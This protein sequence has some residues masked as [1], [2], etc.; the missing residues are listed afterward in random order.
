M[1]INTQDCPFPS[2]R[3][4]VSGEP[5]EDFGGRKAVLA[6]GMVGAGLTALCFC[7]PWSIALVG[8]V[9]V[10]LLS[11]VESEPFLLFIIFL[12]PFGLM[13]E[14][15][16][17]LR[18]VPSAVRSLV[19]V[20]FFLGRLW[21]GRVGVRRLLSSSPARASLFFLGAITVPII[22]GW[23]N[24]S[25]HSLW[26]ASYIGFFFLVSAWADSPERVRKILRVLLYSTIITAV[27]AI[28]QE[29]VVWYTSFWLFLYPP[30]D[31]HEDWRWRAT[32]FLH[33]PN[34]L[35][36]YLNLV[37]PFALACYLLG[38][39]KWK[40]L[41]GWTLG[42]GFVALLS[43]QSMGGT[44]AF[45]SILV[46]AIFCFARSGKKRLVLLAG[47]C[48]LVCL[49][50]LL[51]PILN[52][53]HTEGEVGSSAISR[54]MLWST[55]W[56]YFVRFPVFG[57]G[58]G[59]F[60]HLYGSD[61][62]SFFQP[63]A[64]AVHNIYLQLLAE[65]GLVGFVA[66]LYLVVQSWRQARSQW[67]SSIDFLDLALAFGVLGALLSVLVQG[68]VDFL[69]EGQIP[70]LL[71]VLLALLVASGRLQCKS[72]VCRVGPSGAQA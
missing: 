57:V 11:A 4:P 10:L 42:L 33:D 60:T 5:L 46:L 24:Y 2:P 51:R 52:P 18:D 40:K 54:L 55:A 50:Y 65:T 62:S 38:R 47:L 34:S 21:R 29:V 7:A 13:L 44:V 70:T 15:E 16:G 20:G 41:G 53:T 8:A 22:F 64:L 17:V 61:L 66:F 68:F 28:L 35:A 48:A 43:T 39:G 19:V 14:T 58:W 67:R 45:G 25:V 26:T 12:I 32:S 9:V 49:F 3:L 69:L 56:D 72:V 36:G 23:T 30:A 1:A 59:N 31:Y 27:F 71:W 63:D 37:L 6:L